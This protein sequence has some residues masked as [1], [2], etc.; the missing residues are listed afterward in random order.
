MSDTYPTQSMKHIVALCKRRG[1]I[2][3]G[4]EIYG[5]FANTYSY[6]PYGV[7]MKN[8]IKNLWWQ[9]FVHERA[10]MIG[11]D[12]PILLHPKT[13]KA[14]GHTEGFNDAMIDCKECKSRF[15]IDHLIEDVVHKSVEGK[16]LNELNQMIKDLKISCPVCGKKNFTEGRYF[17][18]MFQTHMSKTLGKE[19]D[20]AF[21]RPETA[22]AIFVEFKN[23][24]DTMRVKLPFGVAQIGKAFRNEITPGNFIFR[25][26]EFEQMEIEYFIK[27]KDWQKCFET[28]LECMHKWCDKIGL[29]K[30]H[31]H[32]DEH[33]KEKLS[34]YS[35]RTIDIVYDFPFGRNELYG[36]A[37][38]TDFDLSQHQKHS[39]VSQEYLDSETNERFIPHVIEPTFGVDRTLLALLCD[40]FE[41]EILESGEKRNV[42]HLSPAIAPVKAAVFPL[43]KKEP[44][45][46]K[47]KEVFQMI[48]HIGNVEY[49][50]GGAIG[51]RYRRQDELGTPYC[52]TID[53]D[54]LEDDTVTLRDRDSM[55]QVRIP[56]KDI[57]KELNERL[58]I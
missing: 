19:D 9:L 50:V 31:L 15:R 12:G 42:L 18:L 23:I 10:D 1:F 49:D 11:I 5:G 53:Y 8:N 25:L 28:W 48:K 43:M 55:E 16:S 2:Y 14:S 37:Y 36:L 35:K 7:E 33:A 3:P 38:R 41:E 24:I 58:S 21:L 40:A 39:K 13:W 44:L 6:G 52:L 27:E 30:E 56:I 51:K 32:E 54:T 46:N 29:K 26:I 47:A 20:V 22:Q 45:A 34:H 17:N 57:V 4:S